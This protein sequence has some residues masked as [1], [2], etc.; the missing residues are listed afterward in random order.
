MVLLLTVAS[1]T[2][3]R[4]IPRRPVEELLVWL[5]TLPVTVN[6]S[7]LK[8]TIPVSALP[9]M[10]SILLFV[11][12]QFSL[13]MPPPLPRPSRIAESVVFWIRLLRIVR[14]S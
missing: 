2:P 4:L 3:S 6:A 8:S 11:I 14:S 10:L 5:T 9:T 1:I 13:P 7:T 12:V